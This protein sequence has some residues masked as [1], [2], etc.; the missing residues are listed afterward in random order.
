LTVDDEWPRPVSDLERAQLVAVRDQ[1]AMMCCDALR[2]GQPFVPFG[3]AGRSAGGMSI[4]G[5]SLLTP[6]TVANPTHFVYQSLADEAAR[7]SAVAI[8]EDVGT[9]AS[10]YLRILCEHRD[11]GAFHVSIPWQ[12]DPDGAIQ[13]RSPV[14]E[15]TDQRSVI[16]HVPR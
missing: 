16:W 13:L 2:S 10:P 11:A 5:G 9:D 15:R 12:R 14:I 1:C 6:P 8:A 7:Y 4:V 3:L